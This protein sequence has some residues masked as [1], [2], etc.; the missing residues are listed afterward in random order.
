MFVV[1]LLFSLIAWSG[2]NEFLKKH[3]F[4]TASGVI[5]AC[6]LSNASILFP[7]SSILI[8]IGYSRLMNPAL[9]ALCAAVGASFGEM[10]GFCIGR[11]GSKV[12]S[13]KLYWW[14][15]SYVQQHG[16][17]MV[18]LFAIMPFPVFDIVGLLSGALE[19]KPFKFFGVCMLGKYVKYAIYIWLA[20]K[21]R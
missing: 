15:F 8:A 13:D 19:M 21:M 3:V 18:F 9:T 14:L 1:V 4:L 2:V 20:Q 10:T 11:C 17:L 12:I 6:F 16:Y 7:S 5:I